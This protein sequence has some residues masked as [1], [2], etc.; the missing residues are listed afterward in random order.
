MFI[1][2]E[3]TPNPDTI[4]F[5]VESR[6]L[7]FVWEC[8]DVDDAKKSIL[9]HKL[10]SVPGVVYLL[11]GYDFVSVSKSAETSWDDLKAPILSE[12]SDFLEEGLN[13]LMDASI[14]EQKFQ[15]DL[16]ELEQKIIIVLD[17][18]VQPAL[19]SH[20]GAVKLV[21]FEAGIVYLDLQGA[22]RGCPSSEAT[23]K[24]GIQNLLRYYFPE[25]QEVRSV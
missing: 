25:V 21:K 14:E 12:I 17:E 1:K 19:E 9:A 3:T 8:K 4:K 2:I 23:L 16:G 18:K 15:A 13:L 6:W 10:F 5:L 11:F 22:C 20:G 7:D 24:F